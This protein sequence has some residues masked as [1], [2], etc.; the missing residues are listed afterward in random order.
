MSD[1]RLTCSP[2]IIALS[3]AYLVDDF[4]KKSLVNFWI[5]MAG[6]VEARPLIHCT[7]LNVNIPH[8]F[9]IQN[10]S[11]LDPYLTSSILIADQ[12]VFQYHIE[13]QKSCPRLKHL[14][15]LGQHT[16]ESL[17]MLAQFSALRSLKL[18]TITVD[19]LSLIPKLTTLSV[20]KLQDGQLKNHFFGNIYNLSMSC[21]AHLDMFP[22]VAC[23]HLDVDGLTVVNL[24]HMH[25]LTK[26][27]INSQHGSIVKIATDPM[28]TSFVSENCTIDS[29]CNMASITSRSLFKS[30]HTAHILAM[31]Q[32]LEETPNLASLTIDY[33][34]YPITFDSAYTYKYLKKMDISNVCIYN[35]RS[36]SL[37]KI[38]AQVTHLKWQN[39]TSILGS[40]IY[41]YEFIS[42]KLD[43]LVVTV[44]KFS[45]QSLPIQKFIKMK[46]LT[47]NFD[48][49][50][51]K[52]YYLIALQDFIRRFIV[53]R[54]NWLPFGLELAC[55]YLKIKIGKTCI[56]ELD[57]LQSKIKIEVDNHNMEFNLRRD[58]PNNSYF[59]CSIVEN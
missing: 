21:V 10:K 29:T 27:E 51:P 31:S 25:F 5:A 12:S 57:V 24:E 9:A 40:Q 43:F 50:L 15:I 26:L 46:S 22:N 20:G 14:T 58:L 36:P 35:P 28:L 16:A 59:N 17:S 19:C 7:M 13:I 34:Q 32:I 3:L 33:G 8:H 39:V 42:D 49:I 2:D 47:V 23:L 11:A 48:V 54:S 45:A 41:P 30:R 6:C 18:D 1:H 38:F 4:D 55:K 44:Y 52:G 37:A 56:E 53:D